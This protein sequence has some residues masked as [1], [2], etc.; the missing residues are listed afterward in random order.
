VFEEKLNCAIFSVKYM[1]N[2]GKCCTEGTSGPKQVV[3]WAKLT[4]KEL[5]I[6]DTSEVDT[7]PPRLPLYLMFDSTLIKRGNSNE[8]LFWRLYL[9]AITSHS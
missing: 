8:N 2:L 9:I 6:K 1:I 5:N 3:N 4:I 7:S